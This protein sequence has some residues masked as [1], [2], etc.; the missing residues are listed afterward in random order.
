MTPKPASTGPESAAPK[1]PAT[2]TP[3]TPSPTVPERRLAPDPDPRAQAGRQYTAARPGRG[4]GARVRPCRGRRGLPQVGGVRAVAA[5]AFERATQA[6]T[7]DSDHEAAHR[8]H[9]TPEALRTAYG[10]RRR[11]GR[12]RPEGRRPCRATP[13]RRPV[14]PR[15]PARA[16]LDLLPGQLAHGGHCYVLAADGGRGEQAALI[17]ARG[18]RVQQHP[19]VRSWRPANPIGRAVPEGPRFTGLVSAS[20]APACVALGPEL[21]GGSFRAAPR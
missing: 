9:S 19:G 14:E 4:R 21:A 11:G 5:R 16:S 15:R 8:V 1:R 18:V 17:A 6:G 13:G 20:T 10:E 12:T 2:A 3:R 7:N